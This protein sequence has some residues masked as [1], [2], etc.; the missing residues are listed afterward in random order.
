VNIVDESYQQSFTSHV[1]DLIWL[2]IARPLVG[3]SH[4]AVP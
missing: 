4:L 3:N 1:Y 2:Q